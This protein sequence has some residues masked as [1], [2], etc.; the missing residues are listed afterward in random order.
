MREKLAAPHMRAKER[1]HGQRRKRRLP[2]GQINFMHPVIL[3][4]DTTHTLTYEQAHTRAHTH[5]H[6]RATHTHTHR[7]THTHTR[8]HAHTRK[9][10]AL[11]PRRRQPTRAPANRK[12]ASARLRIGSSQAARRFVE[13]GQRRGARLRGKCQ[14]QVL[15]STTLA[16][17]IQRQSQRRLSPREARGRADA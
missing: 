14:T 12:H 3:T 8:T 15:R 16:C 11:G 7:H 6:T 10:H 17:V 2:V 13:S 1:P 9:E 5:T 4:F